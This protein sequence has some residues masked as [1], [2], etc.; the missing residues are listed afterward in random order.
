MATKKEPKKTPAKKKPAAKKTTTKKRASTSERWYCTLRDG[1][2]ENRKDFW[3]LKKANEE[4][5]GE[6]ETQNEAVEKFKSLNITATLWFQ[7]GG[8]FI[9]TIKSLQSFGNR[10]QVIVDS[11]ASDEVKKENERR[12]RQFKKEFQL[13]AKKEKEEQEIKPEPTPAP[14]PVPVV[15]PQPEPV[16]ADV[17]DT[18]QKLIVA[19]VVEKKDE[20][21]CDDACSL[22]KRVESLEEKVATNEAL[23]RSRRSKSLNVLLSLFIIFSIII[24]ALLAI[25]IVNTFYPFLNV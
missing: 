25:L 13:L 10:E 17:P 18:R 20:D 3:A 11:D 23:L 5:I 2:A 4:P 16:V 9:R 21:C 8:K 12:L 22:A 19:E 15:E 6:F 7:K 14:T 1:D 24:I